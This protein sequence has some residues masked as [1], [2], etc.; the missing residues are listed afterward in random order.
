MEQ[1]EEQYLRSVLIETLRD[2]SAT[3]NGKAPSGHPWHV[4]CWVSNGRPPLTS[5]SLAT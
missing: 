1:E 2:S 3:Q 4:Y 5:R